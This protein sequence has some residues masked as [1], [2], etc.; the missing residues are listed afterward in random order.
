MIQDDSEGQGQRQG[1][2]D[3][4]GKHQRTEKGHPE[5]HATGQ[6]RDHMTL[7]SILVALLEA[8]EGAWKRGPG[9]GREDSE[10]QEG[11]GSQLLR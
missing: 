9:G 4:I 11:V 6:G 8:E 1:H 10:E 3:A 2:K 5:G 7:A